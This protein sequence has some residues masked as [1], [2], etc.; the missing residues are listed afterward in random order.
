MK[1]EDL[2]SIYPV[3][4]DFHSS[5]VCSLYKLNEKA[6]N[7]Y[8]NRRAVI[9]VALVCAI[10]AI[11]GSA[12]IV[13][14]ATDFF[15]L[16]SSPV[17]NYGLNLNIEDEE[18]P[19]DAEKKHVNLKLGYI[20]EGYENCL[21]SW[22]RAWYTYEGNLSSSSDQWDFNIYI[23]DVTDYVDGNTMGYVVESYE[24]EYNGNQTII[25]TRKFKENKDEYT[26]SAIEYFKDWGYIVTCTCPNLDELLKI[27]EHL[28]LEEDTEYTDPVPKKRED[29]ERGEYIAWYNEEYFLEDIEIGESF[30]CEAKNGDNVYGLTLKIK[31]V[32]ER[33]N[34]AGLDRDDFVQTVDGSR[35]W[36]DLYFDSDGNLITPYTR[37]ELYFGDGVNSLDE[38][39]DVI[40]DRYF[41]LVTVEVTSNDADIDY[42]TEI[43][44]PDVATMYEYEDGYIG[45]ST[46]GTYDGNVEIIYCSY[47]SSCYPGSET[48]RPLSIKKGETM[49]FTYGIVVDGDA[50]DDTYLAFYTA[51]YHNSDVYC[52][53]LDQ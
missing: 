30:D 38:E 34:S 1:S 40:D 31:S 46:S 5:V 20:P 36:H 8:K 22:D 6:V 9:K 19:S 16:L 7:R 17:G 24:T 37:T 41:Y 50:L 15:G 23:N 13:A 18:T 39:L 26:Y 28:E 45:W 3:T 43:F 29:K 49:T 11:L 32:E 52:I 42:L 27:V 2:R 47:F 21:R 25:A 12:T 44:R 10:V 48:I 35:N 33:F 51:V 4:D 53:K 14:A